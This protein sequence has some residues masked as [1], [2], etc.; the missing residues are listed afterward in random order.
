MI[1]WHFKLPTEAPAALAHAAFQQVIGP[2]RCPVHQQ[3]AAV[4]VA[5]TAGGVTVTVLSCCDA[6]DGLCRASVQRP[7]G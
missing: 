5:P 2:L 4:T 3:P 6:L 7:G 1:R